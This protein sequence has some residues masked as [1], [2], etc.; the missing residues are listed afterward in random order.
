[1]TTAVF[2]RGTCDACGK[3]VDSPTIPSQFHRPLNWFVGSLEIHANHAAPDV[4]VRCRGV[5]RDV[6]VVPAD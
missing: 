3:W 1:M 2:E 5:I 4:R 6:R